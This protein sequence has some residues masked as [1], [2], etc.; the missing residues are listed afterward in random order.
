MCKFILS[1]IISFYWSVSCTMQ[2]MSSR[3]TA[4]QNLQHVTARK[5]LFFFFVEIYEQVN[6]WLNEKRTIL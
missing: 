5:D 1:A 2:L 6:R 4:F 3:A